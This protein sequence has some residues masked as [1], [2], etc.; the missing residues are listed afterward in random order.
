[1]PFTILFNPFVT[2]NNMNSFYALATK[3]R[4]F[5][6]SFLGLSIS[7]SSTSLLAQIST[8]CNNNTLWAWGYNV[9]GQLGNG[10]N[11]A[12]NTP[13]QSDQAND[14]KSIAIGD[15]HTIALKNDGSLWA[16][17]NNEIGQLGNG[18]NNNS[19]ILIQIGSANDWKSITAGGVHTIAI[20]ND[21]SLWTWGYNQAG[22][23]GNGSTSN[24]NTPIQMGSD[25][26]WKSVAA[27]HLHTVALKNDGSLWAWG[28]NTNGQLGIGT[29]NATFTPIQIG[30]ANDWKS[31]AAGGVHTTA[32]KN[33]GSLWA[34]GDNTYGQL[35]NATNISNNS[36]IQIGL[37]NDW[38]SIN[39]SYFSTVAIK[40]DGSLWTW[41]DNRNGQL[42]NNSNINSNT[43]LQIGATND[44]INITTGIFHTLAM[45]NNGTLWAWGYNNNGQ[46]GNGSNIDINIPIQIGSTNDWKIISAGG[47]Q[48]LA[49]KAVHCDT[50][51]D[52]VADNLDGCPNDANKIAPGVCGCGKKDVAI[53]TTALPALVCAGEKSQLSATVTGLSTDYTISWDKDL[54]EGD[55][56]TT[57][58]LNTTTIFHATVTT[59]EGC[60][61][62][63][64]ITVEV[65]TAPNAPYSV[66]F[67]DCG[68]TRPKAHSTPYGTNQ[69]FEWYSNANHTGEVIASH[70]AFDGP[71]EISLIDNS[72]DN[73]CPSCTTVINKI[74]YVFEVGANGCYSP[75]T[76]VPITV[77]PVPK[78]TPEVSNTFG[79]G[80]SIA[81]LANGHGNIVEWRTSYN[82]LA[83]STLATGET[84]NTTENKSIYATEIKEFLFTPTKPLPVHETTLRCYGGATPVN[85]NLKPAP[86]APIVSDISLCV[87]DAPQPIFTNPNYIWFTVAENYQ[88]APAVMIN[89]D[90]PSNTTYFIGQIVEG[91][92]SENRTEMHATVN[93][94]PN[95]PSVLSTIQPTC[96]ILTGTIELNPQ[97]NVT[98]S[99]D[100][101]ATYQTSN[102]KTGLTAGLYKIKVK[103]SN[104]CTSA[105]LEAIINTVISNTVTYNITS[106][107]STICVGEI[108]TLSVSP[109]ATISTY[110]WNNGKTSASI[111]VTPL[112]T[113]SYTVTVTNGNCPSII[114]KTIT[115]NPKPVTPILTL[116]QPT[117]SALGSITITNLPSG[118]YSKMEGG[119]WV[120]GKT[121][122]NNLVAGEYEIYVKNGCGISTKEVLLN[123]PNASFDP[124]KCYKIINKNSGKVLDV[125]EN[126]ST[127]FTPIIQYFATGNGNQKW[128]FSV[129]SNGFMKIKVQN[130]SKYLACNDVYNGANVF[131]F[132][133]IAG[134]QK[135][136][137]IECL[138]AG[139]YRILH[140]Y[141]GKYLS[142]E[143]NSKQDK[144]KVE[145]RN[146]SNL[147]AQKW[148][149]IEISCQ[150]QA[151]LRQTDLL[152]A[153]AESEP[154]QVKILWHSNL[155]EKT[156]YYTLEKLDAQ[157]GGFS[158]LKTFNNVFFDSEIHPFN[159]YDAS[160]TEGVNTYRIKA[161][162]NDGKNQVSD[163]LT[164]VFGDVKAVRLYPNPASNFVDIQLPEMAKGE[165][166]VVLHN[167]FGKPLVSYKFE[168]VQTL[169]LDLCDLPNGIYQLNI[170]RQGRRSFVKQMIIQK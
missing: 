82:S 55:T 139:D 73:F 36:P 152:L 41:G 168:G 72:I 93:A 118:Y 91:C 107:Q 111:F 83:G 30:S 106:S 95:T 76:E 146:W 79:C 38:K 144:A 35:G 129:L 60:S 157:T 100:N 8:P 75:A 74:Y 141:S 137:K 54:G 58:S 164:A 14:W 159:A 29:N 2:K 20:K 7:F 77:F 133:Y 132:D 37:A 26:D 148:Q 67:Y 110:L 69:T 32:L 90:M 47:Y 27:G 126:R 19:S 3:A 51:G 16:S 101:G 9:F 162:F 124:T 96:S 81:V 65:K 166:L 85:I 149:I 102:I 24:S 48:T 87:G 156:D 34:W 103:N 1:M 120:L 94:L 89:T 116:V 23:L 68:S 130:S 61:V 151:N 114:S 28:D 113:T 150:N 53:V 109:T 127:N 56:K 153:K 155:G 112:T 115:V 165:V 44:W 147:E 39:A 11:N 136:W 143:N 22:Q 40:N 6:L 64:Q 10:T 154:Q 163:I 86:P 123:A 46:L 33:D 45:K 50:D 99:F 43:P 169:H 138:G 63:S 5:Y 49:L 98:Y 161:I 117:C 70:R 18:T 80:N 140:K 71:N 21:G 145:I 59:T 105:T 128:Q 13:I 121:V 167:M 17:G 84:Y 134:G 88:H 25:N 78:T 158:Q 131:Q 52:G 12:I 104:G 122:Y 31:I 62:S 42:G 66:H 108:V 142:V 160:P 97:I 4:F 92:K 57:A 170:Q 119:S 125:F 135:D 15:Y